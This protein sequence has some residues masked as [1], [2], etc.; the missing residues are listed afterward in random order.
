MVPTAN[1]MALWDRANSRSDR[2]PNDRPAWDERSS[3]GQHHPGTD[4]ESNTDRPV[5]LG[6]GGDL[7]LV[8][9]V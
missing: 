7:E 5:T 3:G 8:P 1:D 2:W 4:A 6:K 9:V